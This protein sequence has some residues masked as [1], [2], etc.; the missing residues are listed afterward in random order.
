MC[1]CKCMD[2]YFTRKFQTVLSGKHL[3]DSKSLP[4]S[5][6]LDRCI[7]WAEGLCWTCECGCPWDKRLSAVCTASTELEQPA[8]SW[9]RC[10]GHPQVWMCRWAWRCVCAYTRD[11]QLCPDKEEESYLDVYNFMWVLCL[12][13]V[14]PGS[15]ICECCG[16]QCPVYGCPCGSLQQWSLLC[17]CVSTHLFG[18]HAQ[19]CYWPNVLRQHQTFPLA[20][21]RKTGCSWWDFSIWIGGSLELLSPLES[22]ALWYL[23]TKP[24]WKHLKIQHLLS[25]KP[26]NSVEEACSL[27]PL[28]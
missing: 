17:M 14:S 1:I 21:D 3:E 27:I 24:L 10:L 22:M 11:L 23:F 8:N 15:V 25:H 12:F 20:W 16:R 19:P 28:V 18:V 4:R 2:V 6:G 13:Y 7:R 26:E 9:G 5:L